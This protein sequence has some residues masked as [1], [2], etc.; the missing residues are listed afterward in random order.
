MRRLR[1]EEGSALVE[2]ALSSTV[3]FLCLFGIL[4]LCG[5]LYT[6]NFVVDAAHEATRYAIVRGSDCTG[7]TNCPL[8]TNATT[9]SA[10]LQTYLQSLGYPGIVA[11]H[12]SASLTWSG[13]NSPTNAPGNTVSV[14][15]TYTYPLNIPFWSQSGNILHLSNTSEMTISQ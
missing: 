3:L 11:N 6:Y 12:L 5:A 7:L 14:T 8:S 10:T 1:G 2:F 9:A 15:V 4:G 13:A